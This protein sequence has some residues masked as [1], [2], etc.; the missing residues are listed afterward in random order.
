MRDSQPLLAETVIFTGTPKSEDVFELVKQLWRDPCFIA[1]YS[2]GG[3]RG[4]DR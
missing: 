3:V 4:A 2:S 1:A